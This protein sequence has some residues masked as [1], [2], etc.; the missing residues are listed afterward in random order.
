MLANAATTRGL[1]H[2]LLKNMH[3]LY[4]TH[5]VWHFARYHAVRG[6]WNGQLPPDAPDYVAR[7]SPGRMANKSARA[8]LDHDW[9]AQAWRAMSEVM[10]MAEARDKVDLGRVVRRRVREPLPS[11]K[12]LV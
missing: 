1:P 11:G 5:A 3:E 10:H 7:A 12:V 6:K 4:R 2:Q 8:K 9:D